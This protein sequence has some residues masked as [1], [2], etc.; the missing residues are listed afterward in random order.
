MKKRILIVTGIIICVILVFGCG[1]YFSNMKKSKQAA[2]IKI[3]Q[4]KVKQENKINGFDLGVLSKSEFHRAESLGQK[5]KSKGIDI[6]G[7]N[8]QSNS[9]QEFKNS[10]VFAITI[11]TP[12]TYVVNNGSE[13]AKNYEDINDENAINKLKKDKVDLN[14][15]TCTSVVGGNDM[16]FAKDYNMVL[17]I[18][19]SDGTQKILHPKYL[20]NNSLD[21][22]EM[23]SFFP[24]KPMYKNTIGAVFDIKGLNNIKTIDAKIIIPN[25]TE[26]DKSFDYNKLN[27][28]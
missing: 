1:Y 20:Y 8:L 10:Y 25:K 6:E 3:K 5:Y 22:E 13:L 28:L 26:V 24:D 9:M 16:N 7:V 19:N 27:Q 21:S 12:F 18:H 17:V 11:W 15:L 23:T 14:T 2:N 4:Q